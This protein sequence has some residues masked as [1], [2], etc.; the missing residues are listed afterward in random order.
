M[1]DVLI[2]L[3]QRNPSV[4]NYLMPPKKQAEKGKG[5]GG[6]NSKS[7]GGKNNGDAKGEVR[8]GCYQRSNLSLTNVNEINKIKYTPLKPFC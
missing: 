6:G 4:I 8:L 2:I 3:F 1:S 7:A 5:G